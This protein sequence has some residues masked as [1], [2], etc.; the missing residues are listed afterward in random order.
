MNYSKNIKIE[1]YIVYHEIDDEVI[2][3]D[4]RNGKYFALDGV[5]KYI[6]LALSKEK[7]IDSLIEELI[8]IYDVSKQELRSD[9]ENFLLILKKEA[10]ISYS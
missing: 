9:I 6:F 3:L 4:S 10:I 7:S 2:I 5:G 1:E 8:N